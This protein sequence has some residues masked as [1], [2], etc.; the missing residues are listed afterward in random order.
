M[1]P[2]QTPVAV[3]DSEDTQQEQQQGEQAVQGVQGVQAQPGQVLVQ[4]PVIPFH[5]YPGTPL[6]VHPVAPVGVSAV[7][8]GNSPLPV[9][10]FPAFEIPQNPEEETP[11]AQEF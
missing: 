10:Q 9:D 8:S 2:G 7:S 5:P 11:A 6:I 4:H 1:T 3:A